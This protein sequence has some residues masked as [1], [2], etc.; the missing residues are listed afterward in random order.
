ML[1]KN[2]GNNVTKIKLIKLNENLASADIQWLTLSPC[3]SDVCYVQVDFRLVKLQCLGLGSFTLC[4]ARVQV[5][6]YLESHCLC[7]NLLFSQ[8]TCSFKWE[9]SDHQ[10][11]FVFRD[12][13][14]KIEMALSFVLHGV[15]Y[16]ME[17]RSEQSS[18]LTMQPG[19][20]TKPLTPLFPCLEQ[21]KG[22]KD[23][24]H[25]PS[26]SVCVFIVCCLFIW[27]PINLHYSSY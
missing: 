9:E 5:V 24:T 25:K 12:F 19:T 6:I 8:S 11:P 18:L 23:Q 26:V 2:C 14:G 10:E 20:P 27:T 4:T 16:T 13:L 22:N 15:P 17:L 3:C 1:E 7:P 21:R